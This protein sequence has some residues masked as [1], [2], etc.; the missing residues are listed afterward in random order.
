MKVFQITVANGEVEEVYPCWGVEP[1]FILTTDFEE[2]GIIADNMKLAIDAV[3][4]L[5]NCEVLT[6]KRN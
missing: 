6:V 3:Q 5:T 2:I 1:E 4:M